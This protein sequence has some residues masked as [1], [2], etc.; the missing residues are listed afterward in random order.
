MRVLF[1]PDY[2]KGVAYQELLADALASENVD[3]D[4]LGGQRRVFPLAR[5]VGRC[6]RDLLH[7]HWPEKYFVSKRDGADWFRKLRYPLDLVL[8]TRRLPLVVTAHDL[9]PHNRASESLVDANFKFTFKRAA[10]VFIHSPAA[11]EA[12]VDTYGVDRSKCHLIHHG[13]LSVPFGRLPLREEARQTLGVGNRERICMMFGTVEPYKGI[14][15]VI[16]H[17]R[18]NQT[19]ATL[20]IVGNPLTAEYKRE[21]IGLAAGVSSIR[22]D[23]AWQTDEALKQ[24]LAACDA[25]VFNYRT[26][27]TSGAASLARSLG[28]PIL[29]PWRLNTIALDEPH[30]LVFRFDD[31]ETD[32]DEQLGMAL[33]SRADYDL[34]GKWRELTNW[35]AVAS[36]TAAVYQS[37]LHR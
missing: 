3:V 5:G 2:R 31:F 15:L 24:W 21:L 25:V 1:A 6:E 34:A 7:L 10:A 32:F 28:L 14:E 35:R 13:D 12:I 37:V 9:R 17:W 11:L 29:L 19:S 20:A 30:P 23:L 4:F 22:M 16:E 26:I 27:L 8:G 18:R 33:Q 36:A